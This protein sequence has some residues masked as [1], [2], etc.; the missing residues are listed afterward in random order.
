MPCLDD[1]QDPQLW[2]EGEAIPVPI[3]VLDVMSEGY[4]SNLV[5]E[6]NSPDSHL[7]AE[8]K[9]GRS[10]GETN[11]T[12]EGHTAEIAFASAPKSGNV[13]ARL[14]K[15]YPS[16]HG[17]RTR[18]DHPVSVQR[19]TKGAYT[20]MINLDTGVDDVDI[21]AISGTLVI[22]VRVRQGKLVLRFDGFTVTDP[23]QAPRCVGPE[24]NVNLD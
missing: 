12:R 21:N 24:L 8:G 10:S 9:T 2:G 3:H 20:H 17:R 18:A 5:T 13:L 4:G 7:G 14:T 16:E 15:F 6:Q 11:H 1:N 19:R 23:L 22:D